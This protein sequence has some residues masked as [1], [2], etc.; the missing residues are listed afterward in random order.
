MF[1]VT[2][3]VSEWPI[4]CMI[5]LTHLYN[6]VELTRRDSDIHTHEFFL[7]WCRNIDAIFTYLN[8]TVLKMV[9][10]FLTYGEK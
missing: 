4:F 8:F 2:I 7:V 9:T 3:N 6:H 1:D 5:M 10:I